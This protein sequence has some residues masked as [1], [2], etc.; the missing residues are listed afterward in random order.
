ML[1][2]RDAFVW[3]KAGVRR[4]MSWWTIHSL[5]SC[6]L[7]TYFILTIT[8]ESLSLT[9]A[10]VCSLAPV[11][12][13]PSV[14]HSFWFLKNKHADALMI[15]T[16]NPQRLFEP[17]GGKNILSAAQKRLNSNLKPTLISDQSAV[18]SEFILSVKSQSASLHFMEDHLK[19]I[20]Q[21]YIMTFC[22]QHKLNI[23]AL[24]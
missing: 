9:R 2:C 5:V 10:S 8:I 4:K 6:A 15:F 1:S 19:S 18:N 16:Q 21:K 14:T 23:T 17:S 13:P 7:R 12:L 20:K 22:M 3:R 11:V 24:F